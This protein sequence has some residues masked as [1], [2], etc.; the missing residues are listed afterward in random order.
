MRLSGLDVRFSCVD[1]KIL[2]NKL[3]DQSVSYI[4]DC[5]LRRR[6]KKIMSV[7]GH[8][9]RNDEQ[10]DKKLL[11]LKQ[12]NFLLGLYAAGIAGALPTETKG[13]KKE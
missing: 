2:I 7:Q 13:T 11:L 4:Y 3:T 1:S 10:Q 9:S 8:R 5:L 6:S 12:A